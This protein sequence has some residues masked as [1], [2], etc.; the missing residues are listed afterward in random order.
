MDKSRTRAVESGFNHEWFDVPLAVL[1]P[2]KMLPA[3]VKESAKYAQIR[4]SVDV[5]GLVEPVVAI[6]HSSIPGHFSILDGHLRVEALKDLG[7]AYARCLIAKDDEGLTYNKR[8]SRVAAIQQHNMILKVYE[9]GVPIDRLAAALGLSPGTIRARF[10]MLDGVCE[11]AIRLL[12]D[13]RVPCRVFAILRQMK[14]FR[15]IDVAHA[16][17]NLDNYSGKF[18]LAM[19][20]TTPD[21]QLVDGPRECATK[22]GTVEA[23]QRLERELAVLQADTKV[24]EENYGPDSLK[25][26]VIKSYLMSL[27]DNARVVRWMAQFRPDYL[28]Q[29]QTI[30]EVKSLAPV[31][32]SDKAA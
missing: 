28:K 30:A 13:K 3:K 20:E 4:S 17:N 26:V 6:P 18:A 11:E 24:I 31:S 14:P 5:I 25:L 21:D 15:Q 12:A 2:S 29:L 19:L 32:A 9:S 22:S 1:H 27:L 8:V 23:I 16:M 7:K 10:R